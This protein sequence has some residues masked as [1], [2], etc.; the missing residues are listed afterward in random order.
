MIVLTLV[1]EMGRAGRSRPFG[2]AEA[3]PI[4][5]EHPPRRHDC[6]SF[7]SH[8]L[9]A[10]LMFGQHDQVVAEHAQPHGRLKTPKTSKETPNQPKCALQ[11]RN[12]TLD[13]GPKGLPKSAHHDNKATKQRRQSQR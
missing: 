13:P 3:A 11:T 5:A 6:T 4:G 1:C 12:S 10:G 2:T 8:G 9:S 7:F